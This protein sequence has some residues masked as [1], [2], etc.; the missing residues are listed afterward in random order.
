METRMTDNEIQALRQIADAV[1]TDE[2]ASGDVER[3]MSLGYVRAAAEGLQVT[4][5]GMMWIVGGRDD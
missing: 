3:L 2:L 4:P 1:P 5:E